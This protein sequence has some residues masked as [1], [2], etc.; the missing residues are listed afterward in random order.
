MAPCNYKAH[1]VTITSLSQEG[2]KI[3]VNELSKILAKVGPRPMAIYSINGPTRTGK[4]FMLG[5][6]LRFLHTPVE[7]RD[8]G[9]DE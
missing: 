7:E 1:A 4:S 3:H 5:Y 8:S 6:F 9:V 2:V